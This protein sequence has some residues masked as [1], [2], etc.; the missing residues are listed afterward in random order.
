MKHI[1]TEFQDN[2]NY[3]GKTVSGYPGFIISAR[4][5]IETHASGPK[6]RS[7]YYAEELKL[8]TN[9]VLN[10]PPGIRFPRSNEEDS[11]LFR[12]ALEDKNVITLITLPCKIK[13]TVSKQ[14]LFFGS[15][16]GHLVF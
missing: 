4:F 5:L 7:W 1:W 16:I 10:S 6:K 15:K 8:E 11:F 3:I 2:V 9:T 13:A 14:V 12:E